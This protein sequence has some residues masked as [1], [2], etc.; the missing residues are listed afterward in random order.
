MSRNTPVIGI[1]L[2]TTNS[3]IS[4]YRNGKVEII[5]NEFGN[6]ITPSIVSFTEKGRLI[7]EA[8]KLQL[9]KNPSNT[10]YNSKRFIGKKI[11]EVQNN[12]KI[13]PFKIEK[14]ENNKILFSIIENN[15]NKKFSPEEILSII[16]SKFKK[17]ATEYLNI[18]VK[19]A[20]IT[21]PASFNDSQKQS[22]KIAGKI[23]DLN[24]IRII[25]EPTSAGIA[26][27]FNNKTQIKKKQNVII[28]DL[29]GGTFDISLLEIDEDSIEVKATKGDNNL[30]GENFDN[31]LTK[32][33]KKE[34][35]NQYKFEL[36]N[37]PRA[38]RRLKEACEKL[39]IDL[40]IKLESVISLDYLMNGKDFEKK[41]TRSDFEDICKDLFLQCKNTLEQLLK[42]KKIDKKKIDEIILVGGGTKMP[43][44]TE[45][46]EEVFNGKKPNNYMNPDE[47]VAI[48]AAIQGAKINGIKDD[49]LN[50]FILLDIIPFPLG[51]ASHGK[52]MSVIIDK[53]SSI[54]LEVKK[55]FYNN[56][57][58]Q[59]VIKIDVY[60]GEYSDINNNH[61]L[62]GFEL[63][64]LPE[65]KKG[66]VKVEVTFSVDVNSILSVNAKVLDSKINEK[67]TIVNDRDNLSKKEIEELREEMKKFKENVN[68]VDSK[69][70]N[71]KL[72]MSILE[73]EYR[74]N[75]NKKDEII[76]LRNLIKSIEEYL[77]L[78]NP[79]EFDNISVFEKYM[80]YLKQLIK[81]YNYIFGKKITNKEKKEIINKIKDYM[82]KI[83]GINIRYFFQFID[84]INQ[85]KEIHYTILI[86][87]MRLYFNEGLK[88]YNIE[89]Y[90][91]SKYYLEESENISKYN[92]L[93]NKI[94]DY[95][96]L[97][98]EHNDIIYSCST[99]L[100]IIQANILMKSADEYFNQGTFNSEQIDMDLIYSSLDLYNEIYYKINGIDLK[101]E[102]KCLAKIIQIEHK[103]LRTLS[104]EKLENYINTCI[105]IA[106]IKNLTNEN[107][108]SDIINIKENISNNYNKELKEK[109]IE[110]I[111]SEIR[112]KYYNKR[113][114]LD[115]IKYIL[116]KYPYKG[117][118]EY[119]NLEREY[120]NNKQSFIH[121]LFKKYHPDI[122]SMEDIN[123]YRIVNT[124]SGLLNE[125][126]NNSLTQGE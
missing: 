104:I 126:R 49:K 90:G 76:S 47:S 98:D 86:H 13:Y 75:L 28:F 16:L 81:Y 62:G 7:G 66:E 56:R 35:Y 26:Y 32:Y 21:V 114:I 101:I 51:I 110:N 112:D 3:C 118:K 33:C 12:I 40:S 87:L 52:K 106:E 50:D 8:A 97:I 64:N 41:I 83:K 31:E 115:F 60:E 113:D 2:G 5:P 103:I 67:I 79:N 54:P 58:N 9:I 78:L 84:I 6:R 125:H 63:K 19:D 23:A 15:I 91:M 73:G 14:G 4:I 82:Q 24:V 94:T 55:I 99:Y 96:D 10:I 122:Y 120:N 34:F 80:F 57:D 93:A 22:T 85:N 53:Y 29:G 102:A 108:Y 39:K 65:K 72:K 43:K 69:L 46:I 77:N 17:L 123:Q 70:S 68:H 45:I 124:I 119:E 38:I 107:W 11:N 1:D 74:K 71:I 27:K 117:Y 111:L 48:G 121:D 25:N 89:N 105:Q 95:K 30:G 42:E 18:E 88:F 44:I 100:K 59:K 109:G 116:N 92:D 20:I 37:N 36:D 61:K